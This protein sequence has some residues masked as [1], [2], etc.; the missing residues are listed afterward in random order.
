MLRRTVLVSFIAVG[1]VACSEG[2]L[3]VRDAAP[4]ADQFA[5]GVLRNLAHSELDLILNTVDPVASGQIDR[6]SLEASAAQLPE[7][8]LAQVGEYHRKIYRSNVRGSTDI[9]G[10]VSFRFTKEGAAYVATVGFARKAGTF[11]VNQLE[12]SP[13]GNRD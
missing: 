12:V 10:T 3:E 9:H 1:L 11:Y 13:R 2:A 6:Q 5:Q 8:F 4:E 7:D